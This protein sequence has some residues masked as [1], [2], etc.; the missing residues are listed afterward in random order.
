MA[1]A[2]EPLQPQVRP[3]RWRWF[4]I[5]GPVLLVAIVWVIPH[6]VAATSLRDL[7]VARLFPHVDGV[8]ASRSASL[9]WF[10]PVEFQ[11]V[12]VI[13]RN[14]ATV[15][16]VAKIRSA[17]TLLSLALDPDQAGSFQIEQA[18]L[19]LQVR[20]KEFNLEKIL[21]GYFTKRAPQPGR[22]ASD[23]GAF[24]IA[25]EILNSRISQHDA[26]TDHQVKI[27]MVSGKVNLAANS[28][29]PV[30]VEL[31]GTLVE[32]N[33]TSSSGAPLSAAE[34]GKRTGKIDAIFH[35][36]AEDK[37]ELQIETDGLT[38]AAVNPLLRRA[39][40]DAELTGRVH[41]SWIYRWSKKADQDYSEIDANLAADEVYLNAPLLGDDRV[42]L[43]DVKLPCRVSLTGSSVHVEKSNLTA[44]LGNASLAGTFDMNDNLIAWLNE[45]GC[46]ASA[47]V[48]LAALANQLPDTLHL[49]AG[50][51]LTSGRARL[52]CTSHKAPTGVAWSGNLT[53]TALQGTR[54]GANIS[55]PEA[56]SLDFSARK[57]AD[58]L[59]QFDTLRCRSRFL[60][61]EGSGASDDFRVRLD[62]DLEKLAEPIGQFVDLSA[63]NLRGQ[64]W[65][66]L[67][68]QPG[69]DK[70]YKLDTTASFKDVKV[71]TLEDPIIEW[72]ALGRWSPSGKLNVSTGS[73]RTSVL[74]IQA[75]DVDVTPVNGGKPIVN[76]KATIQ[77]DINRMRRW[78]ANPTPHPLPL[79]P[80][81]R[82]VAAR[83]I[84]TSVTGSLIA[85]LD[86]QGDPPQGTLDVHLTD[87]VVGPHKAPT[88]REPRMRLWTQLR[89][90]PQADAL[91]IDR[92][93][94]EGQAL[95]CDARGRLDELA[96]DRNLQ[97]QGL[98]KYDL[99]KLE[100]ML[101]TYLGSGAK[102]VGKDKQAFQLTGSLA[103]TQTNLASFV[104]NAE[105]GWKALRAYGGD[106]GPADLKLRLQDGW[107]RTDPV[108]TTFNEGNLRLRPSI[109]LEPGPAELQLAPGLTIDRARITPGM[110]SSVLAYAVPVL[111]GVT[112][113]DGEISLTLDKAHMPLAEP[114]DAEIHGKLHVHNA[115]FGATKLIQ[116]LGD[117]FKT[118]PPA[119][120]ITNCIVPVKMVDGKVYHEGLQFLAGD[121]SV[122]TSGW[123]SVE[124]NMNLLA[125]IQL[126]DRWLGKVSPNLS[127][128]PIKLPIRGTLSSPTVDDAAVRA[129]LSQFTRDAAG[130]L[131]Q[132]EIENGLKKLF[133]RK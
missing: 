113:V 93:Y 101:Q 107:V 15:L 73:L 85:Y 5:I 37:G 26:D 19:Q 10:S 100:P 44:D 64:G 45:P 129:A 70:G 106:V 103:P 109:R 21:A 90:D 86:F 28:A 97:L 104:G 56:L 7:V 40:L 61:I 49:Q 115:R 105:L 62:V 59:P 132:K 88:W 94:L 11:D 123:V 60:Q 52:I 122:R 4:L 66:T 102:L 8:I 46:T 9:D 33:P 77:G 23:S 96:D 82:G 110:S 78:L 119:V 69:D 68:L 79:S 130:K 29:E 42:R 50:T 120:Q 16:R 54:N 117:L 55:L 18:D 32:S 3:N 41:G 124:G 126:P 13:D 34:S 116:E 89:L 83:E 114:P 43:R 53:T 125:E 121:V 36:L 24:C 91:H 27:E 35:W 92:F 17:K 95:A 72:Q 58:G 128:Q 133:Q 80:K 118:A 12:T 14:G 20:G 76:G 6:I 87:V 108:H 65:A 71:F 39:G 47:D 57:N 98:L 30:T 112:K 1:Q 38:L 51:Q 2:P 63:L 74:A 127:K 22:K 25:M 131:L 99:Q 111:A 67:N 84:T 81:G 75:W 31:H 48:D